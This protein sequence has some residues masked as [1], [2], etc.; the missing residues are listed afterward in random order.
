[1]SYAGDFDAPSTRRVNFRAAFAIP[2]GRALHLGEPSCAFMRDSGGVVFHTS[3]HWQRDFKI[4]DS[5]L[6]LYGSAGSHGMGTWVPGLW[7]FGCSDG[8]EQVLTDSIRISGEPIALGNFVSAPVKAIQGKVV[9]FRF[10]TNRSTI[11][12]P[13]ADRVYASRYSA[14]TAQMIWTEIVLEFPATAS[15]VTLPTSCAYYRLHGE[16]VGQFLVEPS[17]EAGSTQ[18]YYGGAYGTTE[19]PGFWTPGKYLAE[20]TTGHDL[21]AWGVF[22]VT[23]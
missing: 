11:P 22:E 7:Y 13:L 16:Q 12:T 18:W 8:D 17:I 6:Y 20:C 5:P 14:A 1:M 15:V 19:S 2:A 9:N 21:V 23:E 3:L 4:P 10:F